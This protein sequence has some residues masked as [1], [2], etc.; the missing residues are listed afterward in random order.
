MGLISPALI[1]RQNNR[2]ALKGFHGA[3]LSTNPSMM[4]NISNQIRIPLNAILGFVELLKDTEISD[5]S[6]DLYLSQ[7]RTSSKYLS[8]LIVMLPT[9]H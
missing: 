1:K 2:N 6:R 7:I 4:I 3:S 8:E 5:V 9:L